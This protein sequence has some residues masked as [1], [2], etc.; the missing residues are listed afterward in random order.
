MA[1]FNAYLQGAWHN[2]A[3]TFILHLRTKKLMLIKLLL[4]PTVAISELLDGIQKKMIVAECVTV[5]ERFSFSCYFNL[6]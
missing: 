1:F 5:G 3:L 2:C 6:K 4:S